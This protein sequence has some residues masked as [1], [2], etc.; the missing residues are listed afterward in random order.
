MHFLCSCSHIADHILHRRPTG[1]GHC[2]DWYNQEFSAKCGDPAH[3][4]NGILCCCWLLYFWLRRRDWWQRELGN[5][6][7]S[8]AYPL[9]LC[10]C[11]C[12]CLSYSCSVIWDHKAYYF[13]MGSWCKYRR[14]I[15]LVIIYRLAA[16]L[17]FL[18]Y[19]NL[20]SSFDAHCKSMQNC[21]NLKHCNSY[22]FWFL[23]VLNVIKSKKY[24]MQ[25][26][27]SLNHYGNL[28][29]SLNFSE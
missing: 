23:L 18:C 22:H 9:H 2:I 8:Y 26:Q 10:D 15:I 12:N 14:I 13:M 1:S 11:K 6:Q 27:N 24:D 20:P 28:S 29:S 4:A 3:Y 7:Y 17:L 21:I 25:G 16:V 5:S 19:P